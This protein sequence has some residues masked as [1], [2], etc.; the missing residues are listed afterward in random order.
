MMGRGVV[1]KP[2]HCA[3]RQYPRDVM[4]AHFL[5][6]TALTFSYM[7]SASTSAMSVP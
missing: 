1:I 7:L 3:Q 5:V 6:M 4:W 2:T